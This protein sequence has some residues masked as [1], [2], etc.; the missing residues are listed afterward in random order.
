M[1]KERRAIFLEV[2][3]QLGDDDDGVDN[4]DDSPPR[5]V[6]DHLEVGRGGGGRSSSKCRPQQMASSA[7]FLSSI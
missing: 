1:T 2:F 7:G 5:G 3:S 4:D 6:H